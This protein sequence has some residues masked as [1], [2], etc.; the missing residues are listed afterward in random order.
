MVFCV[1]AGSQAAF[2]VCSS[3]GGA[4]CGTTVTHVPTAA[5]NTAGTATLV[6]KFAF[7]AIVMSTSRGEAFSSESFFSG[8]VAFGSRAGRLR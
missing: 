5:T 4:S 2:A 3:V 8:R 1:T 7:A 6:Y